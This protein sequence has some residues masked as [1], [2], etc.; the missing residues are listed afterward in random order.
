MLN[1]IAL[2]SIIL[3]SSLGDESGV[4]AVFSGT[5]F[6]LVVIALV[7]VSIVGIWKTFEKAGQ[8]GWG[9]LIPI[10]NVYLLFKIAGRPG[11]WILLLLIPLVNIVVWAAVSIDIAKSFGKDAVF[12]I[13]LLFL[14]NGVGFLVLGYGDAQYQGPAA[15]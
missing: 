3:C 9:S 6:T 11:W 12:G 5:L 4:A 8:P 1:A 10:Y 13:V 7:I 15:A 2:G 14:L